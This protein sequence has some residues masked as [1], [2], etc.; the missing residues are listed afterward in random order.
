[1]LPAWATVRSLR[2]WTRVWKPRLSIWRNSTSEELSLLEGYTGGLCLLAR[3]VKHTLGKCRI[4]RVARHTC[5]EGSTINWIRGRLRLSRR[6]QLEPRVL[7][8]DRKGSG[9]STILAYYNIYCQAKGPKN[10]NVSRHLLAKHF[11]MFQ[12]G[13]SCIRVIPYVRSLHIN[14]FVKGS[15]SKKSKMET[16]RNEPVKYSCSMV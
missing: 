7:P 4:D 2:R 9:G 16:T 8:T 10:S 15:P 14:A 6:N 5:F 3:N 11:H 12:L 13:V 1:V